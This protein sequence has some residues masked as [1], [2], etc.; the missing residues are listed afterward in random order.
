MTIITTRVAINAA[1][2]DDATSGLSNRSGPGMMTCISLLQKIRPTNSTPV[3]H[4]LRPE[5]MGKISRHFV[6]S[7]N[8]HYT[9]T[10]AKREFEHAQ[11]VSFGR[12]SPNYPIQGSANTSIDILLMLQPH[13]KYGLLAASLTS[14]FK[15]LPAAHQQESPNHRSQ[16]AHQTWPAF[17]S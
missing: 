15:T 13:K 1:P 4:M 5:F 9:S 2:D 7:H 12:S 16:C 11:C 8:E 17:R 3:V 6:S 14:N 10:R